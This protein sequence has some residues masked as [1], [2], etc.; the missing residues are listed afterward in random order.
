MVLGE[1]VLYSPS[2]RLSRVTPDLP[3]GA[4]PCRQA[5]D[6]ALLVETLGIASNELGVD[7]SASQVRHSA[8]A[9]TE[10]V[11]PRRARLTELSKCRPNSGADSFTLL[12]AIDFFVCHRARCDL[13]PAT[14]PWP[15]LAV[16]AVTF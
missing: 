16:T 8:C 3:F 14:L 5:D 10:P 11:G 1:M 7:G 2:E 9:G 6:V 13:G 15:V 12:C 4:S